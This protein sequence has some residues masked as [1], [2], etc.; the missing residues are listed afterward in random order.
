VNSPDFW[1]VVKV[2]KEKTQKKT[3]MK[4]K[5]GVKQEDENEIKEIYRKWYEDLLT[6]KEASNSKEI[7][8]KHS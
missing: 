8:K 6:Q 5:N 1:K 3:T 4:D 2:N 7:Q